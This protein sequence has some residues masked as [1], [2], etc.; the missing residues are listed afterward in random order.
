MQCTRPVHGYYA[1]RANPTGKRSIVFTQG[2]GFTDMPV[3]VP[4]GKCLGCRMEYARQW[5]VRCEHEIKSH[6]ENAFVTLTYDDKAVP[7][8]DDGL[9]T[10]SL[11][12]VTKFWKR[13][14]KSLGIKLRYFQCGEYGGK[15]HRPHYH[16]II[17]GWYPADCVRYGDSGSGEPL[18]ESR[19]LTDVWGYGR[20]TV[21]EATW[22]TANYVARYVTKKVVNPDESVDSRKRE[23]L[24]MSRRPGIGHNYAQGFLEEWFARD[25]LIGNGV[26]MRPPKYYES[27][28]EKRFPE[29]LSFVKTQR[30]IA[31]AEAERK[32]VES[33]VTLDSIER[34]G[35]S[36]LT[37]LKRD[38]VD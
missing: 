28:A 33:H 7:Y 15:T 22:R 26:A 34:V 5:A 17:F 10:L 1:Q 12:D 36:R 4:C 29:V 25:E 21:Q 9:M 27:L 32:R 37:M 11:D 38:G 20:C 31:A 24:T 3:T 19:V 18:Y 8:T 23:F 16:A 35:E 2:K 6:S 30:A 14:R 13:L